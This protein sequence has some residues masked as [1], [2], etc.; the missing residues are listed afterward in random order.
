MKQKPLL[1]LCIIENG[2]VPENLKP[3]FGSYPQMIIDWLSPH[4]P[5]AHFTVVSAVQGDKLPRADEFDGYLL[6][7]SKH[8]VYERADWMLAE[9]ELLRQARAMRRPIFGICFGHQL[10]ADAFG[11]QTQKAS[12][13]WGVGAQHYDNSDEGPNSGASFIFHQDQVAKLPDEARCIG[14]SGHCSHGVLAYEFPALSVQY[15]PEF[16]RDYIRSLAEQFGGNLLPQEIAK[17]ALSSLDQLEVD[18]KAVGHW[19]ADFFRKHRPA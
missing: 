19:A 5:E 9:I 8:S 2:L 10:M 3:R 7:G 17:Q 16:T 12:Q 13:G 18:N 15:H 1:Q 11:G 6:T 14:G 4:L